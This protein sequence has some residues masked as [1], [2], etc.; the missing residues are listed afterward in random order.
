MKIHYGYSDGSGEYR[1]TI[2]TDRCDGCGECQHICP[3]GIFE[4]TVDDYDKTVVKVKDGL[5]KTLGYRCHGHVAC[6]QGG[7]DCHSA[8]K[9]GAIVHSW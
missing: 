8:C 7:V 6:K 1:I 9:P 2:D 5:T 3:E 4:I